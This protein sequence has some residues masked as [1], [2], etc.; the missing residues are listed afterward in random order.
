MKAHVADYQYKIHCLRIEPVSGPAVYITDYVRDIHLGANVYRAGSGYE[1]SGVDGPSDMSAGSFDLEGVL[2]VAGIDRDALASGLYDG[3]FVYL[4]AT[5]WHAPVEDDEPI[6]KALLGKTEIA[7][8]R[9]KCEAM[10]LIDALDQS[11]GR[12]YGANCKKRFGGTEFAGCK[13]VPVVRTATVTA[14][15]DRYTFSVSGLTDPADFF[16]AGSARMTSGQNAVLKAQRIKAYSA[17]VVTLH[18]AMYYAVQVGDTVELTEG[19][20]QRLEDC[21]GKGNILNF[22][23]FSFVPTSNQATKWGTQ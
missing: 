4:F 8:G 14:I 15:A 2:N 9:Y 6:A 12:S 1:F 16:T 20:M 10:M 23:G 11:T 19:C 7:D 3:A 18:D 5:V 17:G 22:G 21:K 13:K